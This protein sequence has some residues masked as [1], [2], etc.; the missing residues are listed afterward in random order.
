MT[1]FYRCET[2]QSLCTSAICNNNGVCY[3]DASTSNNTLRCICSQGY[4]G[5]N[6]ESSFNFFNSCA[7]NSCGS[8]GTCF[9]T[10]I[11]L[12][13]CICP[14]GLIGQSCNSSKS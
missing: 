10:S 13:Y 1:I 14:N 4:T 7:Q 2:I 11:S 5:Q 6:C 8:N 12:Y 9:S 3:V